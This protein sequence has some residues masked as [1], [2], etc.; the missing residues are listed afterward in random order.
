MSYFGKVNNKT[1][2][3]AWEHDHIQASV[4][5]LLTHYY[6]ISLP[7]N[8]PVW[9]EDDYDTIYKLEFN[10]D[11]QLTFSNT[12]EGISNLSLPLSCPTFAN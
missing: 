8:F 12:C 4:E 3:V 5:Y 10:N 7:T 6:N 9:T 11:G 2:L 1:T